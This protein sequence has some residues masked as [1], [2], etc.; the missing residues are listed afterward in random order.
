ML[1]IV[2]IYSRDAFIFDFKFKIELTRALLLRVTDFCITVRM[3]VKFRHSAKECQIQAHRRGGEGGEGGEGE[4]RPALGI[5]TKG[6]SVI[7]V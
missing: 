6:S 5:L 4:N 3:W 7:Y 2:T 1:K